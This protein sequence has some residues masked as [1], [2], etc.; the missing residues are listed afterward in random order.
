MPIQRY[1]ILTA[2]KLNGEA[3][4]E[5]LSELEALSAQHADKARTGGSLE[6]V[7][8][9]ATPEISGDEAQRLLALLEQR[10]PEL[11]DAPALV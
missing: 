11:K 9:Q 2:R 7:W 6:Q 5:E 4:P 8:Q 1:W 3:T 10:I